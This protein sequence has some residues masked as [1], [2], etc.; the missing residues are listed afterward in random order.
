MPTASAAASSSSVPVPVAGDAVGGAGDAD[1]FDLVDKVTG[2]AQ[3]LL[4]DLS[5]RV[6]A[7]CRRQ[8]YGF[9]TR[10]AALQGG[11]AK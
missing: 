2:A 10:Y 4:D 1:G 7:S 3:E 8:W 6:P 9:L 5:Q 11:P